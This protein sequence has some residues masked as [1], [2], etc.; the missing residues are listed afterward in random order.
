MKLNGPNR[1]VNRKALVRG[2]L[3]CTSFT[4]LLSLAF[5]LWFSMTHDYSAVINPEDIALIQLDAPQAGDM[6]AVM[7]TDAGDMTYALYPDEAPQTVENFCNLAKQGYYDGSYVFR[8]EPEI[9]FSAGAPNADG[10]VPDP[11]ADTE[12]IPRELSAKLW[13]FRGALCALTTKAN[14]GFFRTLTGKQQYYTG[15]RFLVADTIEMTDEIRENMLSPDGNETQD[16]V[17]NAFL[18]KGGIPNYSQ[19]IT[20]FGQLIEGYDILDAITSAELTGEENSKRPKDDI[21]IL[22]IEITEYEAK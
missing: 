7:H 11:D 15:S 12:R 20:V 18:E 6:I 8:V 10:T 9:F 21:R 16:L 4:L 13:P 19:Q 5:G 14:A 22:S 3:L 1:G 17:A 2:L